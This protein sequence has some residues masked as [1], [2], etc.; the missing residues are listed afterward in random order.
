MLTFYKEQHSNLE[1]ENQLIT[2]YKNVCMYRE[3]RKFIF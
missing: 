2:F 3:N 1:S